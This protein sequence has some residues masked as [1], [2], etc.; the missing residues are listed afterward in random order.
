[1]KILNYND[2]IAKN[3]YGLF[4]LS[5]FS[6]AF[7]Y[8]IKVIDVEFLLIGFGIGLINLTFS[9]LYLI[10]NNRFYFPKRIYTNFYMYL[11][12]KPHVYGKNP[13]QKFSDYGLWFRIYAYF[14]TLLVLFIDFVVLKSIV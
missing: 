13:I 9:V 4:I 10:F 8:V 6:T 2:N 12:R 7:L 1:M 3:T 11:R 14:S 5:I